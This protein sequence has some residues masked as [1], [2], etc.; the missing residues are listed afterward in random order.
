MGI[1]N[2]RLEAGNLVWYKLG[3]SLE[4]VVWEVE[5]NKIQRIVFMKDCCTCCLLTWPQLL[6][7]ATCTTKLSWVVGFKRYTI[8]N[9]SWAQPS[10]LTK[11]PWVDSLENTEQNS[12]LQIHHT[13]ITYPIEDV[14]WWVKPTLFHH[15]ASLQGSQWWSG[16]DVKGVS[17]VK[18]LGQSA[19]SSSTHLC[20]C[21]MVDGVWTENTFSL[22]FHPT[23]NHS[24]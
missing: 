15:S 4:G 13:H 10:T 9:P 21:R 23:A 19:S 12:S 24:G 8:S 16:D 1:A 14:V 7:V 3:T 5:H 2:K 20:T 6:T 11:I 17:C 22:H 18:I